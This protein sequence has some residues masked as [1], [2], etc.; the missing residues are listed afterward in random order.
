MRF[1]VAIAQ[2][3]SVRFGGC[4]S[5]SHPSV[6]EGHG[7]NDR[8]RRCAGRRGRAS[9]YR[10]ALGSFRLTRH[11]PVGCRSF[12]SISFG[13]VRVLLAS[14]LGGSGHLLPVTAVAQACRR[15][16]HE[17]L[18]VVPPSLVG[19]VESTGLPH[20]VGDEPPK[21]FIDG[22][23]ERLRNGSPNADAG[24][25][26][27]ELF[28][29]RGT[30]DMLGPVR[31]ACLSWQPELIVR[32]PC[33][34]ASAVVAHEVGIAQ[35]QV[36]ISLAAIERGVLDMVTP[37]IER[38]GP[39]VAEVIAAAPYLS[40]FPSSLDPSPWADTR[41]FRRPAQPTEALPDWWPGGGDRPLVYLTFGTVVGH[42]AEAAGVYRSALGAVSGLRARVLLTTGRA[43]DVD[44]LGPVPTNTHVERWVPQADV[45]A[46][47]AAVV[48]HGGSGT[49][50]GALASGTP[51][52]IC[53]LFADQNRNGQLVKSAGAGLII[54]RPENRHDALRSLGPADVAPMRQ[55]IERVLSDPA[56][57]QNAQRI[58]AEMMAT[59]TLDDVIEKQ[60]AKV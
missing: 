1:T 41:R 29:G 51:L 6:V 7:E 18:L 30:Q 45:L 34:Y 15:L 17:V 28:A 5:D 55:A 49:T 27:R 8:C 38:Y 54:T 23:W 48:C 12:A 3:L 26:D 4:R 42:L 20:R 16:G 39:G 60:P 47:A 43:M 50:F 40:S 44:D 35:A 2:V 59:P 33:E 31:D 24:L 25:I 13:G 10:D 32:E 19:Q 11:L 57:R 22:L 46:H 36:G 9:H 37:I 58:S 14:S 21:E 56:Y 52:V 53:P